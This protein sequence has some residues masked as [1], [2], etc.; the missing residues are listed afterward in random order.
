MRDPFRRPSRTAR[1]QT[2]GGGSWSA[3][4]LSGLSRTQMEVIRPLRASAVITI[5]PSGQSSTSEGLE[6][7]SESTTRPARG[8]RRSP[9]RRGINGLAGKNYKTIT[10]DRPGPC[11]RPK[12][13]EDPAVEPASYPGTVRQLV[14]GGLGRDAP[15]VIITSDDQ[16]KTRALAWQY[17]RRMT[18]AQRLG[19]II[20]AFCADALSS[21]V[22]LDVDLDVV[23]CVL[24]PALLA[25]LRNRLGPSH[26]AATPG[27]LQRRFP[28]TSTSDDD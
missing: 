28:E 7:S 9:P 12:V 15:A 10:L 3:A 23:L 21:T 2:I 14:A 11:N 19:E 25:A 6:S 18:I 24:A 5:G 27:T 20:Q 26:A 22:N 8:E 4:V 13:H 17:A 16:I 1:S